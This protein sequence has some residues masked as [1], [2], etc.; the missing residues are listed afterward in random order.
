MS[1]FGLLCYENQQ[2]SGQSL[3]TVGLYL[4]IQNFT[5]GQL[6]VAF[7]RV[8][9]RDGLGVMVNDEVRTSEDVMKNIVYK[10]II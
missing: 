7:S 1:Y 3:N 10:K 4:P 8:T 2:K 9:R 6:Y 5:D